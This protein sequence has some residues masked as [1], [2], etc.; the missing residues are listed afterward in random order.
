MDRHRYR[1]WKLFDANNNT[2]IATVTGNTLLGGGHGLRI[3][4][5]EA[6]YTDD[7]DME[8]TTAVANGNTVTATLTKQPGGRGDVR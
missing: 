7:N 5:G 3:R 4:G 6:N 1:G 8:V 2:V